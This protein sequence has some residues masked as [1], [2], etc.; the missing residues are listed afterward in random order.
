MLDMQTSGS[1]AGRSVQ[2]HLRTHAPQQRTSL[3][4]HLVGAGEEVRRHFKAQGLGGLQIDDELVLGGGLHRQ[5]GRLL[6]LEDAI[7]VAGCAPVL[8]KEIRPP[9]VTK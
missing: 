3:F 8:V 6:T 2:C 5:V 7:Y 1:A 4:D 9:S